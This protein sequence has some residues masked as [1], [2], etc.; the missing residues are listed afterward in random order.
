MSTTITR[1]SATL[2]IYQGD[3]LERLSDLR[4][5]VS[6]AGARLQNTIGSPRRGGDEDPKAALR[7]AQQAF[8]DF[9]DEAAERAVEVRLQAMGRKPFRALLADHPAR[10][11]EDTDGKQVDHDDDVD[12]GAN[13]ETM[14]EPLLSASIVEPADLDLDALSDGDAERLFATAF[15]LNRSPGGDPKEQRFSPDT[16]SSTET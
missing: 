3:D 15:W 6:V 5:E 16:R 1:R 14:F 13:T 11:V 7:Q 2:V 12:Y 8:D 9:V 4:R 10:Q